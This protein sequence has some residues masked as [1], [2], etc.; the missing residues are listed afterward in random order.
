MKARLNLSS[1]PL[2]RASKWWLYLPAVIL[3]LAPISNANADLFTG[4]RSA[5]ESNI[6]INSV[7]ADAPSP[8]ND[9][10]VGESDNFVTLDLEVFSLT[11]DDL[12]FTPVFTPGTT[13]YLATAFLRNSTGVA[14]QSFNLQIGTG[15]F[16]G[17]TDTFVPQTDN[18][19]TLTNY[20]WPD[21]DSPFD[22]PTWSVVDVDGHVVNYSNGIV[23]P[24][25]SAIVRFTVDVPTNQTEMT[26]RGSLLAVPEPSM[27]APLLIFSLVACFVILRRRL[28]NAT[29]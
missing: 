18:D 2:A 28:R 24:G 23:N 22:S 16:D 6:R 4:V 3:T 20:D 15:S 17:T 10:I 11:R 27:I 25:E 7:D 29:A 8:D 5:Y 21:V 26:F 13:E 19:I 12:I 9:N 14:W 1:Q